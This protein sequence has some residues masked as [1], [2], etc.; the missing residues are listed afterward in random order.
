VYAL[1]FMNRCNLN[2][3]GATLKPC[4]NGTGVK[5]FEADPQ[6]AIITLI[7]ISD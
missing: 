5:E 1:E 2:I 7:I 3:D 6:K 4:L